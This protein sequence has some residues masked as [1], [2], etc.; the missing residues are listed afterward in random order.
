MARLVSWSVVPRGAIV[1][2]QQR[3]ANQHSREVTKDGHN[4]FIACHGFDL[5]K[6]DHLHAGYMC[7]E[8]L[9]REHELSH[10]NRTSRQ[11]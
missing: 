6:F 3:L 2:M 1:P 4:R 8:Q 10:T 9:E 7:G 11:L 5:R